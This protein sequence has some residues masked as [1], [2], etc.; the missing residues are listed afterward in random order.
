M[1]VFEC[2]TNPDSKHNFPLVEWRRKKGRERKTNSPYQGYCDSEEI[3]TLASEENGALNHR[4]RPLG[5]TTHA[6]YN[7]VENPVHVHVS[8]A[9]AGA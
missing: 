4:L 9:F 8:A 3:R 2:P 6:S 7:K 5:H 1:Q